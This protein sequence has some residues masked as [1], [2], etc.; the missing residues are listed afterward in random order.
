MV[1]V[2]VVVV[3]HLFA[4]AIPSLLACSLDGPAVR[5]QAFLLASS[6]SMP[7]MRL[8]SAH[9]R[10]DT[11]SLGNVQ[12]DSARPGSANSARLG[13]TCLLARCMHAFK[14]AYLARLFPALYRR[15]L[16]RRVASHRTAL[17]LSLPCSLARHN[18]TSSLTHIVLL[19]ISASA[20]DK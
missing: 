1:V 13:L 2:V 12:L 6:L 16:P 17:L 5:V 19:F 10:T 8:S 14:C 20:C 18:A 4:S 9:P 15:A 7:R 11:Q 3:V